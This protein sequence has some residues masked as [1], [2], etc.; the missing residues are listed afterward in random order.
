[1][2][3]IT[4]KEH[5]P[6]EVYPSLIALG[7]TGIFGFNALL[8]L[9]LHY[10]T[11]ASSTLANAFNPLAT[12][13]LAATWLHERVNRWQVAGFMV[14]L[15]GVAVMQ[16]KGSLQALATKGLNPGDLM[17]LASAFLW[18]FYS[19][20]GR[21]VMRKLSPL[22][23]T[24]Y[25]V[26]IGELLLLPAAAW[27]IAAGSE[28]LLSWEALAALLYLGVV[29]SLLAYAWWYVAIK[30]V[31]PVK[32]ANFNNLLPVYVVALAAVFLGEEIQAYHFVGAALILAGLLLASG[33][34][35]APSRP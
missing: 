8:Y 18:A 4:R 16:T 31:G 20:L 25:A 26:V 33:G 11:S 32:A 24:A 7:A 15:A 13:F 12:A 1:M 2:F 9:G 27:E 14:S 28:V 3:K 29:A 34:S 6:R 21:K 19:V 23:V 17:I 35:Q 22:L 30:E 5:L 10:T